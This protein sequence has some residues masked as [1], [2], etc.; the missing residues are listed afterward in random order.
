MRLSRAVRTFFDVT[1]VHALG[2]NEAPH[3]KREEN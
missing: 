3:D 2:L 1:G